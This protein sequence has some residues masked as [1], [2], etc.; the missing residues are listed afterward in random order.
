MPMK[1][2][3]LVLLFAVMALGSFAQDTFSIVAL[4]TATRQVGSAGASCV[5]LV[6]AGITDASFLGDL[7]PDTGAIN[8][9]SFY[10]VANQLA[11]RQRM[12]SGDAPG[13][14]ITYLFV[15]DAAGN[16]AQ[17]QYG[18]VGFSGAYGAGAAFTGTN[19]L[20]ANKEVTGSIGGYYYAIQG[21]ILIGTWVI[22]SMEARFRN[23]PGDLACRMMAALQGANSAGA[24]SRCSQYGTSS[25][26][27][28]LKVANPTDT[29]GNPSLQLSVLA[30]PNVLVFEPIDSLQ[31]LF[32]Q[33]QNCLP[34]GVPE[35]T[36]GA[37][38]L[39]AYPNPATDAVLLSGISPT[40]GYEVT[41]C[42]GRLLLRGTA[43]QQT[44]IAIGDLAPGS[45][46]IR[47]TANQF[48]SFIKY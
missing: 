32:N 9:Q 25:L 41:D 40:T 8:T 29:Y 46:F 36:T 43:G 23:T 34:F 39:R 42:A 44:S 47:T 2:G 19:C 33:Q 48:C 15:N 12:R 26:F 7:L 6:A 14:I 28:F 21:N 3:F 10:L 5:D 18:I 22:D 11:A 16:P 35:S 24:D 31:T 17:R 30:T 38:K 27:A 20:A 4:D 45:Y 37:L 1:K 13:Q